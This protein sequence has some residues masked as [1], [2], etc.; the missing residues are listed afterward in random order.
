MFALPDDLRDT[1]KEPLGLLVDEQELL[2]LLQDTKLI[3]SVGDLV[4]YTLLKNGINPTICIVDY[5]LERKEYSFEMKEKIKEYCGKH[6]KIKNP[7]GAITDELWNG[8]GSCYKNLKKE[9]FCIEIEGEEDL[10]ALPAIYLAPSDVTVIYGLPNRGV[11]VVK[12]DQA[13]KSK[14]KEILDRM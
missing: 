7:P 4:T 10:A 14:V 6:I 8:I 11:V 3:V 2:E 12:A 1:L 9:P 13:H 5:I